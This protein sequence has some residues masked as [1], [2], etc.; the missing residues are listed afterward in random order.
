MSSRL[1]PS[2]SGNN[3]PLPGSGPTQSMAAGV[4]N[5]ENWTDIGIA[6][7]PNQLHKIVSRKG[8]NFTLMCVGESGLGKTTLVNTLFTTSVLE[9][10]DFLSAKST[11][12]AEPPKTTS[13]EITRAGIKS[14]DN[15]I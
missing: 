6:N 10:K 2:L 14:Q 13:I 8:A 5:K 11:N 15:S 9:T 12:A 7:L 3:K 1:P 4:G